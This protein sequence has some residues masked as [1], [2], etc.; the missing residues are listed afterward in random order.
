M[1]TCAPVVQ[2][3][4]QAICTRLISVRFRSR[5]FGIVSRHKSCR[6]SDNDHI[7]KNS[8]ICGTP[9]LCCNSICNIGFLVSDWQ[10]GHTYF[11][12]LS[13]Q[14]KTSMDKIWNYC[15]WEDRNRR[16]G[17]KIRN[18]IIFSKLAILYNPHGMTVWVVQANRPID[19]TVWVDEGMG[20]FIKCGQIG[21]ITGR[22]TAHYGPDWLEL[23][24][25]QGMSVGACRRLQML[26]ENIVQACQVGDNPWRRRYSLR[27]INWLVCSLAV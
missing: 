8:V 22:A 7:G 27:Y 1:R 16:V 14:V 26:G 17:I 9:G 5:A 21:G 19:K 10:P 6:I 15:K 23:S 11:Q 18:I 2:L 24:V 3:A 25:R 12:Y 4:E 13:R 20:L